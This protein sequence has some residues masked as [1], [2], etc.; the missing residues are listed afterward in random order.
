MLYV[1]NVGTI[2]LFRVGSTD[3]ALMEPEFMTPT[4]TA[5]HIVNLQFTQIY[6]RLMIDGVTSKPFS[7]TTLPPIPAPIMKNIYHDII[8]VSRQKYTVPKREV[9][10][11]IKKWNLN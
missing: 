3:A 9:E 5:E 1:G 4:F 11:A 2:L 6:L 7:A 10:D 8:F